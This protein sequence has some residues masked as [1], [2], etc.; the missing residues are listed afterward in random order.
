MERNLKSFAALA[1]SLM[2]AGEPG[3]AVFVPAALPMGAAHLP[4]PAALVPPPALQP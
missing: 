2:L 3:A 1:F 4:P